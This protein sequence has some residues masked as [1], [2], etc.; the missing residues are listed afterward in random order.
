MAKGPAIELVDR[1]SVRRHRS[2]RA[3]ALI[4]GAL[5]AF[6][7]SVRPASA[8][9]T[10]FFGSPASIPGTIEAEN[11]DNG[12]EGVAFH[13]TGSSTNAGGQY[14]QTG[15]DIEPCSEG[16]FDVGWIATGEWLNYTVYVNTAGTYT[17]SVRVASPNGATMHVGFN[18]P[19]AGTWKPIS[20]PITGGWQ[21]WTNVTT[22]VTLGAGQQVM[23]LY[24]DVGGYN[25]TSIT[26]SGGSAPAPPPPAPAPPPPAPAPPPPSGNGP[27][28]GTAVS[29]P[30]TI[31]AENF[32]NGADGVSYHD[33]GP[34]N[35]GGQYRNNTNA[36]IEACAEGGYDVGWI[37]SGEWANYSVNVSSAGTY[38]VQLRVASPSGGG[39]MH[40]GFNTTSNVW[41]AV[42]IP[43]TGGWQSWTTV[44][45]T[46][47]LG[48]GPQ[49]MTL[50]YDSGGFNLNWIK[51]VA[52]SSSPPPPPPPPPT[53]P[54]TGS[55]LRMMTWN[56]Q[57]GKDVNNSYN[58]SAQVNFMAAQNA[59]VYVLQEVQTWD[60]YQPDRIPAMLQAVRGGTWYTVWAPNTQCQTGG[61]I[62]ELIVSRY[63][64]AASNTTYLGPSSAGRALIYVNNV[65]VNIVTNHLEYYDT[66]LRTTELYGLMSFARSF[67][68]L[69]LVGGDFNSWWG[70]WWISQMKTEYHDTWKD[71]N[72]VD[73]GAY[74]VGNVRFDYIF[75][76]F[77]SDW[78]ATPTNAY[79]P[80]T[81]TSDHRPFV[82]DFRIQ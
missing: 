42:S 39:S 75:R 24:A 68:G 36:D 23:T 77:D 31:E 7:V 81:S 14:R 38:T 48:A 37:S 70:E 53:P 10:P 43:S 82:A 51:V 76:S 16:G 25:L 21:S 18:G 46:V 12:G 71:V 47:T 45:L 22:T 69:R 27:Y 61:C 13:D 41:Q 44:S 28:L 66:S 8:Q 80:W 74:T 67:G 72:G 6:G 73:D 40:V 30:G 1:R 60:E 50:G 49:L 15:V 32:D 79:V 52:G 9:L 34:G 4:A 59:D 64:I 3:A 5:L 26:V 2:R 19:S 20:V 33:S 58:L 65:P 55:M 35:A 78:R 54:P 63:P 62:G 17:V 57:A 29:I 11:F 56:I